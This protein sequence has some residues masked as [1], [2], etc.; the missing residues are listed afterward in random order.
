[1][2]DIEQI[3]QYLKMK[4]ASEYDE[5]STKILKISSHFL[6]PPLNYICNK[7]LVWGVFIERLK[8]TV[9]EPLH[10]NCERCDVLKL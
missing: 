8:Y 7:I 2:K 6:S 9:I 3:I 1:M 10:K 5:I 4:N